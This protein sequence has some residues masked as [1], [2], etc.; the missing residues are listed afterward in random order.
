MGS[1]KDHPV[2]CAGCRQGYC[3]ICSSRCP[4][5]NSNRI[6]RQPIQ[7]AP[8]SLQE[9]EE[10]TLGEYFDARSAAEQVNG[11]AP[12]NNQPELPHE[13]SESGLGDWGSG[14]QVIQQPLNHNQTPLRARITNYVSAHPGCIRD[15]IANGLGE[16]QDKVWRR[17][18]ECVRA[19]TV[20]YGESR[21]SGPRAQRTCWPPSE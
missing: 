5:C 13:A 15:E 20:V 2:T 12:L 18:S 1:H 17:M 11:Q 4:A 3:T 9:L 14:S 10:P 8:P 16:P 19:G 6:K 21:T 7:P